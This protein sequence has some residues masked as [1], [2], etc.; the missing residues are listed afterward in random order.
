[1]ELFQKSTVTEMAKKGIGNFWL[2]VFEGVL[3]ITGVSFISYETVLPKIIESLGGPGLLISFAPALPI[4]GS[5]LTPLIGANIADR[6]HHKRNFVAL[7]CVFQRLPYILLIPVLW[8]SKDNLTSAWLIA[9]TIFL[10][11]LGSGILAPAWFQLVANTV[12]ERYIPR[13]FS[14]RF[15]ISSVLGVLVGWLVK[16]ILDWHPDKTGYGL[17]FLLAGIM[18]M[19]GIWFLMK[20]REPRH[21]PRRREPPLPV[22][23]SEVLSSPNIVRFIWLRACYCGVFVSMA[24]IPIKICREL[25][26][27]SGWLGIFT[28]MVVLGAI[29][30]N[31]FAAFWA[32]HFSW[33]NGL[34]IGICA[35]L[36][37]FILTIICRS[38]GM[39]MLI[40]F[41][42][43]F[44]K[45]VWNSMSAALMISIPGQRL[46]SRGS[47]MI[48]LLMAPP[49]ICGSVSG[50]LLYSWF[51]SYNLLFAVSALMMIPTIVFS[52]KLSGIR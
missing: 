7:V 52:R 50:T 20:I 18:M 35:Y 15:G 14:I 2:H 21:I 13:L 37:V 16:I 1:M 48:A 32:Q 27:N 46:R 42:L 34:I 38:T 29:V 24:Y 4:L 22:T 49:I 39:A 26:L 31:V 12:Q 23:Y 41:I 9:G 44:A 25:E 40:F 33:K 30:G 51:G 28:M 47:A 11:G 19:S 3:C 10:Y 5:A 43:G 36:V 17:L 6:L 45:D 8:F